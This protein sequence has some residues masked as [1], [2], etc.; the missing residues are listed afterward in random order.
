MAMWAVSV[1]PVLQLS[2][3]IP[4]YQE[5]DNIPILADELARAGLLQA[6]TEVVF[7]DDGSTDGTWDAIQAC[8]AR[9][10]T[11]RGVRLP[12]NFGQSAALL[13][14]LRAAGGAVMAMMDGDLQ[15]DPADIPRLVA[16]LGDADCVC[17][18]REKRRDS[19][20]RRAGSRLANRVRNLVTRDGV[21]DTGCSLKVFRRACADDLPPL[22]GVHRFIPAYLK[23]H[24]RRI[25]EVP[26]H[27]RAR[28]HGR[29]KYTN[30]KRLP[31]TIVDLLGF[32][33]YRQRHA[34]I[35][36]AL[37][38]GAAPAGG[39]ASAARAEAERD[40]LAPGA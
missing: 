33:W 18:Y 10:P 28:M 25:V 11:L 22:N 38:A 12:R 24:G 7:V 2:V 39:A 4:C 23:L 40:C 13:A 15:S 37:Q 3:V 1:E 14:G 31:V 20:S 16:A 26:V 21:R 17:G 35:H 36:A 34:R 8:V 19:W 30:L 32:W 29:S 5:A 9:H 27:H 6:G